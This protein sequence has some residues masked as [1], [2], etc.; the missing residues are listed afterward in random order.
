MINP[1]E[2][3]RDLANLRRTIDDVIA[4]Q[5]R[6]VP[7]I[8][9]E[10]ISSSL[11]LSS[12]ALGLSDQYCSRL[13]CNAGKVDN[14]TFSNIGALD[15]VNAETRKI[16]LELFEA[17]ECDVRLLSGLSG[18]T[19]LLFAV[20]QEQDVLFRVDE[21]DGGHLSTKPIA[22]RLHI[23]L[24]DMVLNDRCRLDVDH[25]RKMYQKEK[26]QAVFFDSSYVLFP[27]PLETIRDI[28][29]PDVLILYDASHVISLI[30]SGFFQ[31]PFKEGA[32]IIHS[33]THKTL[34]GPQKSMILFREKGPLAERV[35]LFAQDLV[36]NTHLHHIFA[37]Y[38]A[39]L[40]FRHFG[41]DYARQIRKNVKAFAEALSREGMNVAAKQYGYSESNQLWVDFET[42]ENAIAQFKK[43]DRTDIS[44]NVIFLPG[45]HWGW[46]IAVNGLTRLGAK[47]EEFKVLAR[48]L[49]DVVHDRK[50]PA[51]INEECEAL[52][53]GLGDLQYCFDSMPEA[54]KIQECIF[55]ERLNFTNVLA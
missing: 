26:P 19:V 30:A 49:S 47:E 39:L 10:N 37:L 35:H 52:R 22:N 51:R 16:A 46:R 14:L 42:K 6:R 18:L 15:V 38:I 25:F 34:W 9:S 24:R 55:A 33:T 23:N 40:E 3:E 13:P 54:Q 41:V 7:L 20:L 8:S 29:G 27:Y 21:A 44:L 11:L 28:V 12:Y 36:S 32:D 43:I 53:Q 31:S 17:Q 4:Y 45:G 2:V 50:S 1:G 48:I 5:K